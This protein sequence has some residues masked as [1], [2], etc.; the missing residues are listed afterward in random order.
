MKKVGV[1]HYTLTNALCLCTV[2]WAWHVDTYQCIGVCV[3][4]G[5]RETVTLTSVLGDTYQCTCRLCTGGRGTSTLTS[6]LLFVHSLLGKARRHLPVYLATLTSVLVVC[7]LVGV[8]R[9]HL[10]VCLLFFMVRLYTE[11][12]L[13]KSCSRKGVSFL[14]YFTSAKGGRLI[15]DCDWP[16]HIGLLSF[17]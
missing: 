4:P 8:A 1:T 5:G 9:P 2:W 7:A 6:V 3:Q 13:S 16:L 12:G 17:Q 14:S 10:P 11:P 15:G